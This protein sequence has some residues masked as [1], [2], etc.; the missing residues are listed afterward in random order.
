[1]CHP[2]PAN[3]DCIGLDARWSAQGVWG[4]L[5]VH[6]AAA[7]MGLLSGLEEASPAIQVKVQQKGPLPLIPS[8]FPAGPETALSLP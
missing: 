8:V 7:G 4:L 1:M 2:I 5:P 3:I 6:G